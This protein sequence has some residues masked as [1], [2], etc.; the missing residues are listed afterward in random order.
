MRMLTFIYLA[1][2]KSCSTYFGSV[3]EKLKELSNQNMPLM[4]FYLK[5]FKSIEAIMIRPHNKKENNIIVNN[6]LEL[7]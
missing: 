1:T 4:L 7:S 2:E 5:L 6:I 3:L